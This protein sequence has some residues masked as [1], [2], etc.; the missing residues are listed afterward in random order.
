MVVLVFCGDLKYCPYIKRYIERLDLANAEYRVLFWN[1]GGYQLELPDNFVYYNAESDLRKGKIQKLFDFV[2]F[3]NWVIKKLKSYEPRKI[4]A[5]S[6]LTGVILGKW[7]YS[8]K[9]SYV[10]DIRDYS[11]EHIEPF[12]SIEKKVIENSAF[13]AISS[14]GFKG[15][16]PEH[17][18][19]VA[20]N[21]NRNDICEDAKFT[22]T[23][24]VIHFV[25]N[26]VVRYFEYQK[27]YLDALKNDRRF[28][29]VFHGDGPELGLYKEYCDVNGFNN[30]VFTGSYDNANKASLL[31]DAQILNNCYGY[32]Q[33][34]RNKLKYAIS[35][36]FY[37]GMIYHIP[38]FVEPEGY[39][40]DWA[41]QS[42]IGV[43]FGVD[44]SFADRLYDYYES[45]DVERF[46]LACD[47]ALRIVLSEDDEYISRI[48]DFI[49]F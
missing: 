26:G 16:L 3:R 9:D 6:T 10:F 49:K 32:T 47:N 1:R 24:G 2:N 45:I 37:D 41:R 18:Y 4:I 29:I 12:Y 44:E 35:N 28:E 15:F 7:L 5:L 13:T 23:K 22:K 39:K 20:H 11:Y 48:D 40:S 33:G 34:A 46:D 43:N 30:I 31:Q 17:D 19:V 38:Q 42:G 36:R 14:K 8:R 27:Q 21:F 25:W